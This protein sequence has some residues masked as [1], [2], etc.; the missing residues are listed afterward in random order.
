[1]WNAS[2]ISRLNQT[3]KQHA[4]SAELSHQQVRAEK[5]GSRAAP[6]MAG[7]A[8][9]QNAPLSSPAPFFLNSCEHMNRFLPPPSAVSD[10]VAH[11][12]QPGQCGRAEPRGGGASPQAPS[13][14]LLRT[15]VANRAVSRVVS[16]FPTVTPLLPALPCGDREAPLGTFPSWTENGFEPPSP[17][18]CRAGPWPCQL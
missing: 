18:E 1:M 2:V 10:S 7:L 3:G 15:S 4:V 17:S 14:L 9:L 8:V 16:P 13:L 6:T 11:R 5:R 12:S